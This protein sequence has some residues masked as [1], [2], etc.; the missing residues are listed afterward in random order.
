[1]SLE[2]VVPV[3]IDP[4]RHFMR[5]LLAQIRFVKLIMIKVLDHTDGIN[6]PKFVVWCCLVLS[7]VDMSSKN[8]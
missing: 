6:I 7:Q 3:D 4:G 8:A 5:A 1:M 2:L